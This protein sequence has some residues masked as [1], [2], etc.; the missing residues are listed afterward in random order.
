MVLP[1]LETRPQQ[2]Q[3]KAVR[4]NEAVNVWVLK[5]DP[6]IKIKSRIQI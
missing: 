2:T 1:P 6:G 3:R 5:L 4:G